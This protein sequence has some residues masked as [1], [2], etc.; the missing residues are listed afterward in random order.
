MFISLSTNPLGHQACEVLSGVLLLRLLLLALGA[1]TKPIS[2]LY[3]PRP[4]QAPGWH[5][6]GPAWLPNNSYLFRKLTLEHLDERDQ[7]WHVVFLGV[8][9]FSDF[10]LKTW[11]HPKRNKEPHFELLHNYFYWG[12]RSL[13]FLINE[14]FVPWGWHAR[15]A[16]ETL[17]SWRKSVLDF[18]AIYNTS[19]ASDVFCCYLHHFASRSQFVA[20]IYNTLW[21]TYYFC[22]YLQHLVR[23]A[24]IFGAIRNTWWTPL[25]FLW[26]FTALGEVRSQKSLL[27]LLIWARA[28]M[29]GRRHASSQTEMRENFIN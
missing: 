27:D 8:V 28:E 18:G 9:G 11:R 2:A 25:V 14:M 19:W 13:F 20:A 12:N 1:F 7:T 5:I 10:F 24:S 4:A 21:T 15:A 26:V 23:L 6:W 29:K 22:Y 17:H 3:P 16:N